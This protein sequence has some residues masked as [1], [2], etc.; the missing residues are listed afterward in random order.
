[1]GGTR[2]HG[3]IGYRRG[4]QGVDDDGKIS[5]SGNWRAIA[6]QFRGLIAAGY[7]R[8]L[9]T[10]KTSPSP[11]GVATLGKGSAPR[12]RLLHSHRASRSLLRVPIGIRI[13]ALRRRRMPKRTRVLQRLAKRM[14]HLRWRHRRSTPWLIKRLSHLRGRGRRNAAPVAGRR[15]RG[16]DR[17][18]GMRGGSPTSHC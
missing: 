8:K 12:S 15:G 17:C 14:A 5:W 3:S 11:A 2:P 1:M 16:R 13:V 6:A 9:I 10:V 7:G 4:P 18:N